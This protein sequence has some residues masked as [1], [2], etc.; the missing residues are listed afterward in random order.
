VEKQMDNRMNGSGGL[1]DWLVGWIDVLMEGQQ[2]QESMNG[3]AGLPEHYRGSEFW[4]NCRM[5]KPLV[6]NYKLPVRVRADQNV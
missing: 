6:T 4:A 3:L 1:L 5:T 2:T